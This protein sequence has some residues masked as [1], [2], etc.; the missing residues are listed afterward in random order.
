[1][2]E[3]LDKALKKIADEITVM[4]ENYIKEAED[5]EYLYLLHDKDRELYDRVWEGIRTGD[6]VIDVRATYHIP[7][8]I[9]EAAL[10]TDA[11]FQGEMETQICP[12]SFTEDEW[13]ALKLYAE[14]KL[15]GDVRPDFIL[16]PERYQDTMLVYSTFYLYVLY[17]EAARV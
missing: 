14:D 13:R 12:E 16:K 10:H 6:V 11:I 15:Q 7:S 4:E 3:T 1:M 5:G 17:L 8:N 9:Q 2:E